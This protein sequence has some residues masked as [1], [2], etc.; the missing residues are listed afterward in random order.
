VNC[1][2]TE[3]KNCHMTGVGH[4]TSSS[5]VC[6]QLITCL[7]CLIYLGDYYIRVYWSKLPIDKFPIIA[8]AVAS[9]TPPVPL[10]PSCIPAPVLPKIRADL[11]SVH[12]PGLS[13]A[14]VLDSSDFVVDG[15]DA[16]PG[17]A[18]VK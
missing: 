4:K 10:P 15:H 2:E 12:G 14:H 16:G 11:V 8:S 7:L 3:L 9:V 5:T 13:T 17:K 1:W 6:N 18:T